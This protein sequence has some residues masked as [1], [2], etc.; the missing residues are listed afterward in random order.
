MRTVTSVFTCLGKKKT[1]NSFSPQKIR[2]IL[3]VYFIIFLLHVNVRAHL[4]CEASCSMTAP[5]NPQVKKHSRPAQIQLWKK[6]CKSTDLNYSLVRL[7]MSTFRTT[8]AEA[9][10]LKEL[11]W[12]E[13][14]LIHVVFFLWPRSM[15]I[16]NL[17]QNLQNFIFLNFL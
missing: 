1:N 9:S 2:K 7:G 10:W 4:L 3:K 14:S 5:M 12:V 15:N 6:V 13:F 8:F 16:F 17:T 11:S